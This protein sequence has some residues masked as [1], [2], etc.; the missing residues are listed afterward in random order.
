MKINLKY[1]VGVV[2][3][4]I[5]ICLSVFQSEPHFYTF[6]SIG[7]FLIFLEYYNSNNKNKLFKKWDNKQFVLFGVLLIVLSIV[8][9]KIGLFFN[10]WE[11]QYLTLF[12]EILKYTFE[13]GI[14][15]LYIMIFFMIG[16]NILEK[17][18]SKKLSFI[19]SLLIFVTLIGFFTEFIN[20]FSYSWKI[21]SMPLTNY[22]IGNY[23]IIFQTIGYWLVAIIPFII[24]KFVNKLK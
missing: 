8:M 19:L 7:L 21:L 23:F 24:Y 15:L 10:Y 14:A 13:W 17:K 4:L 3:L 5:G 11:Y 9:D 16:K 20:S 6:F 18:F 22:K 12:D 1:L 2:S